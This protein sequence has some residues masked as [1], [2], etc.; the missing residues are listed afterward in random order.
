K[1]ARKRIIRTLLPR[2]ALDRGAVR[3]AGPSEGRRAV[4]GEHVLEREL[5]HR[6]QVLARRLRAPEPTGADVMGFEES[7][8]P[9]HDA[10]GP[11]EELVGRVPVLEAV[12]GDGQTAC[13]VDDQQALRPTAR[14]H[15]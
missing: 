1:S 10:P 2:D 7:E 13:T 3:L 14:E 15:V 4:R 8:L 12:A 5:E 9:H 6:A 11:V